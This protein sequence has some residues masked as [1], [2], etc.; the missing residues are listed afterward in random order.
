MN[1]WFFYKGPVRVERVPQAK[2]GCGLHKAAVIRQR[3][4]AW[5][6]YKSE[7]F[8]FCLWD[9]FHPYWPFIKEPLIHLI[10]QRKYIYIFY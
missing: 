5:P 2:G 6:K 3:K 9:P 7:T 4:V 10:I 1:K 8:S